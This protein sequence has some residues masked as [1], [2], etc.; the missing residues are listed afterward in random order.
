MVSLQ[1]IESRVCDSVCF[2]APNEISRLDMP[3]AAPRNI[4]IG[5]RF[6]LLTVMVMKTK[7]LLGYCGLSTGIYLPMLRV[8]AVKAGEKSLLCVE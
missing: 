2:Y 4:F 5:A 1:Y 8:Q 7:S 6:D 3:A